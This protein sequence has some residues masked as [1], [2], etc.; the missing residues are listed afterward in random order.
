MIPAVAQVR[1]TRPPYRGAT[2]NVIHCGYNRDWEDDPKQPLAVVSITTSG[3]EEHRAFTGVYIPSQMS[4]WAEHTG[5][6]GLTSA[7]TTS[8]IAYYY[9]SDLQT[10][11]GAVLNTW[12][13]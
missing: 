10:D 8:V 5:A 1:S 12:V 13:Q 9:P 4:G 3:A 6:P 2:I 7:S 11:Y